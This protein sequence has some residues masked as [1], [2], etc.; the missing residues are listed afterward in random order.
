MRRYTTAELDSVLTVDPGDKAWLAVAMFRTAGS[1]G[2]T[3]KRAVSHLIPRDPD[4]DPWA[5]ALDYDYGEWRFLRMKMPASELWQILK[6]WSTGEAIDLRDNIATRFQVQLPEGRW[7]VER[8]ASN[9]HGTFAPVPFPADWYI[10]PG[11]SSEST[12][13]SLVASGLPYYPSAVEACLRL[14]DG[15][16]HGDL[17]SANY[18]KP[19]LHL[20]R[21]DNRAHMPA[22]ILRGHEVV[23]HVQG[24]V[25]PSME[26]KMFTDA[27]DEA[28]LPLE[29]ERKIYLLPWAGIP[30]RAE[31]VTTWGGEIV[32][33]RIYSRHPIHNT[34]EHIEIDYGEEGTIDQLLAQGESLS[35][36][37]KEKLPTDTKPVK[38]FL[39]SISAFANTDGGTILVGVSDHGV[40]HGVTK[41][42]KWQDRVT[43]MVQ[44]RMTPGPQIRLK[45]AMY[46]GVLLYVIE[47][48][49]GENR[50]YFVTG[51]TIPTAYIR[52]GASDYPV[53]R[54]ELDAIYGARE[55]PRYNPLTDPTHWSF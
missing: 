30:D 53:T 20:L 32:D 10:C 47:V 41:D 42:S 14:V 2:Y 36:E 54:S 31:W 44:S 3:I 6:A 51:N 49:V 7:S 43:N 50:P 35:L 18:N 9:S 52:H 5:D 17:V 11:E 40:P 25:A 1:D 37:F 45:E 26:L 21:C 12:R 46:R 39:E 33:R 16:T 22:V 19:E 38:E 4:W 13:N 23:V 27:G 24:V 28:V 55:V 34:N 8:R 29:L 48:P 15:L